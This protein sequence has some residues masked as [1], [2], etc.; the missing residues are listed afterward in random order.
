MIFLLPFLW[1]GVMWADFHILRSR[2]WEK[3][4]LKNKVSGDDNT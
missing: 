2:A 4:V 3:D 1:T